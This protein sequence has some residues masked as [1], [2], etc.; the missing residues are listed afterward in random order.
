[1][2]G[3]QAIFSLRD[4]CGLGPDEA[5]RVIGQAARRTLAGAL[6]EFGVEGVT[7]AGTEPARGRHAP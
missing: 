6:A 2:W 5:E 4:A 1:M 7:P 3:P